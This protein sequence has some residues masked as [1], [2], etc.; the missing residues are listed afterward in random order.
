MENGSPFTPDKPTIVL[1]SNGEEIPPVPPKAVEAIAPVSNPAPTPQV[2]K[3]LQDL[4]ER[5]RILEKRSSELE[6]RSRTYEE[7]EAL[8]RLAMDDPVGFLDRIGIKTDTIEKEL[9]SRQ[10]QDP[11]EQLRQEFAELKAQLMESRQK[12][13]ESRKLA[14]LD[15]VKSQVIGYVDQN[16]ESYPLT[17]AAGLQEQVYQTMYDHFLNTQESLSEADAAKQVEDYLAG[18]KSKWLPSDSQPSPVTKP[19]TLTNSMA[20]QN[21]SKTE[22]TGNGLL[23]ED[24]SILRAAAMLKFVQTK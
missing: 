18:I 12:E 10:P 3:A 4:I 9:K 19:R 20:A 13:A 7:A 8:K 11:T 24:D 5:E 17:V 1:D 6:K 16:A 15:E 22:P 23:S 21:P 2:S 14:A